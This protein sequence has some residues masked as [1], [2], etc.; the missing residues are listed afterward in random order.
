MGQNSKIRTLRKALKI[1]QEK[2]ERFKDFTPAQQER[3]LSMAVRDAMRMA[4]ERSRTQALR[5]GN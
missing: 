1:E 5:R 3:W 2:H 4:D